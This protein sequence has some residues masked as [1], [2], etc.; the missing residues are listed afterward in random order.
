MDSQEDYLSRYESPPA[1]AT[2]G[3]QRQIE[4]QKNLEREK[5]RQAED[6]EYER[7]ELIAREYQRDMARE[8][9]KSESS[10]ARQSNSVGLVIGNQLSNPDPVSN[11]FYR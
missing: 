7:Q 1:S 8:R 3:R 2:L 4:A 6:R 10:D 5:Q 9:Q 11:T